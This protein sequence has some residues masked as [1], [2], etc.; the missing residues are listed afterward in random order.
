MELKIG[1]LRN[2][3]TTLC[4][5]VLDEGARVEV[6]PDVWTRELVNTTVTLLNP[7]DALPVGVGRKLN[8]LI[9]YAEA[10]QL[11]GGF[12]SAALMRVVQPRFEQFMDDG[13]LHG[14]YGPRLMAQMMKIEKILRDEPYSRQAVGAIWDNNKDPYLRGTNTLAKDVPCTIAVQFLYRD[15]RLHGRFVMRSNDC[16]WGVAYDFY[17]FATLTIALSE[18]LGYEPGSV[19]IQAGSLHVYERDTDAIA[20]LHYTTNPPPAFEY[21][22]KTADTWFDTAV[23]AQDLVNGP[24]PELL[25]GP[26]RLLREAAKK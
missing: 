17:Q 18:V 10:V 15:S 11:V 8:P 16:Y 1:D 12:S 25:T 23:A 6:R 2:G 5:R 9:A 3:Y 13:I 24:E 26:Q 20:A 14:A 21:L 4:Q 22:V 19:T 7:Y